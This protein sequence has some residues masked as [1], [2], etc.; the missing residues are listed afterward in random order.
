[1][2]ALKTNDRHGSWVIDCVAVSKAQLK[3]NPRE[4]HVTAHGMAL[5]L[6]ASVAVRTRS[7]TQS[8]QLGTLRQLLSEAAAF[9]ST[10]LTAPGCSQVRPSACLRRV[11]SATPGALS[12]EYSLLLQRAWA[13][14]ARIPQSFE[15]GEG[16]WPCRVL[17][18][19]KMRALYCKHPT[20][21]TVISRL[22]QACTPSR[23]A[24][25]NP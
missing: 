5:R 20:W 2:E 9:A 3:L 10:G 22:L 21:R 14:G 12:E 1:M 6:Q 23:M 19:A 24:D 13:S 15:R 17:A 7:A 16:L 11:H 8:A 25:G 18:R 4:P